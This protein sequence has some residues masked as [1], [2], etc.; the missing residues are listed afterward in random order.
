MP[1]VLSHEGGDDDQCIDR[2]AKFGL[3]VAIP[4]SGVEGEEDVIGVV[5]EEREAEGEEEVGDDV[6]STQRDELG[7]RGGGGRKRRKRRTERRRR[8]WR[9]E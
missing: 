5:P 7:G 4:G 2:F 6:D 1:Y 9:R 3:W 8:R